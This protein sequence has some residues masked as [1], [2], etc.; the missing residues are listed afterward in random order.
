MRKSILLAVVGL[1]TGAAAFPALADLMK[2]V[3]IF[4][5]TAASPNAQYI[6]IQM[7]ASGQNQVGGE[8]ITLFDAAGNLTSTVTFPGPVSNGASQ[9]K[10]LIATSEAESFF[11]LSADLIMPASVLSAGGKACWAGTVDCVAW[12][13]YSGATT[14]V[15]EPYHDIS[16]LVSGKAAIRRLDRAGLTTV[17]DAGD[18]TDNSY[19]D[20]FDGLPAPRNNARILGTTPASTCGNGVLEGLEECDD[21][22]LA[23]GDG[24]S[25]TCK[26]TPVVLS[27]ADAAIVEGNSGTKTMTFTVTLSSPLAVDVTYDIATADRVNTPTTP[28]ATAGSDYVAS[29]LT[30]QVIPA[31]QT[32]K[33]FSVPII[34]D[35][36]LELNETFAV[37]LGN[38]AR[39]DGLPIGVGDSQAIGTI[40]EDDQP[41]LSIN[42]VSMAEGNSGTQAMT[43]TVSLSVPSSSPV[44]YDIA[45]GIYGAQPGVDFVAKSLTGETIPA[46]QTSKT[47]TVTINGD[48]DVEPDE[49]IEVTLS[50]A[51]GAAISDPY[52]EG[53]ILNDDVATLSIDDVSMSEGD[54]GT[55]TM[56]FTVK[57][58]KPPLQACYDIKT[59]NGT[60]ASGKATAGSD[61]V[62][63][64]LTQ[65]CM[66]GV[67]SKTFTVTINGDTTIEG[68]ETFN[69]FLEHASVPVSDDH[70]VGTI[71]DDDGAPTLSISDASTSEGNSGTKTM[72]FTVSLSA[73]STSPV[74]YNILTASNTA[75]GGVDYVSRT[76]TNETIPAGTLSKTFTVTVNGDTTLE[77]NETFFVNVYGVVG[78]TAVDPT[79]V[80]TIS[81]DDVSQSSLSINNATVTEGNSGSKTLTF[82]VSLSAAAGSAV[83]YNISTA[84]NTAT[85]G[86][87]YV[88]SSLVGQSIPA[89]VTS[90]TFSVTING[91]TT[92]EPNESFYVNVYGVQGATVADPTGVGT[93]ANDDYPSL[94]INNASVTE[95][96]SGT[97]TMTFTVSLSAAASNP[98]TYSIATANN[99][100]AAGSDYVA[101]SLNGQTI[102]AGTTSK[103][104]SVTI[105]GDTTVEPNETFFA[106]V[107]SVNGATV[108]D[109][110]GVGTIVNDDGAALRIASVS[111]GGLVDDIDDGNREP[112]LSLHDYT[113]LLHDTAQRIC[114]RAGA[115]TIVAV[116]DVENRA[117]LSDLADAT[118]LTCSTQPHYAAV[119]GQGDS[120]G[121]LIQAPTTEHQGGLSVLSRPETYTDANATALSVLPAGQSRPI[122]VLLASAPDGTPLIRRAQARALAQRVQQHLAHAF[123]ENLILF[124]AAAVNGL[125][126]L[127]IRAQPPAGLPKFTMPSDR[128]LVSPALL[129]QFQRAHVEFLPTRTA[130]EAAQYLQLQQ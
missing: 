58:D 114:E 99:T 126:D 87:D 129:R 14:G 47:F 12:G 5:G 83:T 113:L 81:N 24:C 91:D 30:D 64:Q 72:T 128:I 61:Y 33:T 51:S 2:I 19:N 45:T 71:V 31:G 16:G 54:S 110:T 29:S 63:K 116:D 57:A 20:F 73:A 4:P 98:V 82:T 97:S 18:D 123:D 104:F 103:T 56:T 101:S 74:T 38:V 127:T 75:T 79:G 102:P 49:G 89:G 117:V 36:V 25:S 105:N 28:A 3:E 124:G 85:A 11:G 44:T 21:H 119:M 10:I 111:T 115:A 108:A 95:G 22:N 80:G 42:D 121:F 90:K 60:T 86:S 50:N 40:I 65:E 37:N 62:A 34:G 88:A 8:S 130:G 70:A 55:K 67:T 41:V 76:L 100:A 46:G 112:V 78:A 6:V 96:N 13:S 69:V 107:Y 84:N 43:F 35:T 7:Y 94:S 39:S 1:L 9:D 66:Y 106:N 122:T 48:Q 59:V 32:S 118:N 26:S 17:L 23:D 92:I 53:T 27:I 77:S 52:G 125:V 15:G 93:I 120:R 109:P 68:D